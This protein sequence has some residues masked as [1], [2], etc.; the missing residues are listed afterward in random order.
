MCVFVHVCECALK[1]SN[2]T[3]VDMQSMLDLL[4]GRLLDALIAVRFVIDCSP[5]Y[6]AKTFD[7]TLAPAHRY[8]LASY[9]RR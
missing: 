5:E 9:K 8:R 1:M 4:S 3:R 2:S 7:L 6:D